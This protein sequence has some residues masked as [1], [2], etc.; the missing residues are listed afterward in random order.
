VVRARQQ[1]ESNG[2]PGFRSR[3]TPTVTS[4]NNRRA[5]FSVHGRCRRFITDTAHRL[6]GLGLRMW[7]LGD[8][9]T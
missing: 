2:L 6:L 1:P 8:L 3:G 7:R 5:V 4:W 9:K